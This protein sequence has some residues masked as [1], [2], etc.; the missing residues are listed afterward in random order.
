MEVT[1]VEDHLVLLW[2]RKKHQ[3][4]RYFR[5]LVLDEGIGISDNEVRKG[6]KRRFFGSADFIQR[7]Y[8]AYCYPQ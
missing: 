3:I 6:L 4:Q 1:L 8:E 2:G 5:I 7:M